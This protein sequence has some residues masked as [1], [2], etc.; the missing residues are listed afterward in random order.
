MYQCQGTAA[1][2][3]A[4][5]KGLDDIRAAAANLK[6]GTSGRK[7][8][9]SV[10]KFYGAEN[11]NNGVNIN[12]NNHDPNALGST[13]TAN[14]VTTISF[15]ANALTPLGPTGKVKP[16]PMRER[17]ALTKR[18]KATCRTHSGS[19]TTLS[20]TPIRLNQPWTRE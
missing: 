3:A 6:V 8:L 7:A 9:D 13:S 19:S 1:Q 12:F 10:L 2:C 15:G 11:T 18:G 4:I 14:G 16:S 20:T 5:K 17:T